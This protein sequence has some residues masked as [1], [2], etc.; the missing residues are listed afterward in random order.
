MAL[1]RTMEE[2][3]GFARAGSFQVKKTPRL[4][5]FNVRTNATVGETIRFS[6]QTQNCTG[7]VMRIIGSQPIVRNLPANGQMNLLVEVAGEW[8]VSIE[9]RGD[10]APARTPAKRIIVSDVPLELHLS[11]TQIQGSLGQKFLLQWAS[12]G[13]RSI[14]V[15]RGN[16]VLALPLAGR[17]EIEMGRHSENLIFTATS[18]SGRTTESYCG[19]VPTPSTSERIKA[20]QTIYND[21]KSLTQ[22]LELFL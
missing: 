13:A 19:L 3:A 11:T 17:L 9:I 8:Q 14:A 2:I 22:P 16:E 7:V 1:A 6:W 4:V 12:D 15:A 18:T 5:N 21:L 20:Q 10:A